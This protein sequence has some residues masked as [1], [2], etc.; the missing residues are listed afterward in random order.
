M[1]GHGSREKP[2][3]YFPILRKSENSYCC[4]VLIIQST[5]GFSVCEFREYILRF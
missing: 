4:K 1:H 2:G 3:E 5:H